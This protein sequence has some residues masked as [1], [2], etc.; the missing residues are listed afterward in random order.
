MTGICTGWTHELAAALRCVFSAIVA[1]N[2]K[3]AGIREVEA[4]GPLSITG[5]SE[6]IEPLE[7]L[8]A[9]FVEAGR[10]TVQASYEAPYRLTVA[11]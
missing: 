7:R 11:A 3:D 5:P 1:G 9:E 8:L 10:M 2:I 6:I 4:H